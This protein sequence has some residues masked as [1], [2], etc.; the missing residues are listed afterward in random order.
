MDQMPYTKKTVYTSACIALCVVLPMI[1]HAV[2][3]AGNVWLPMHFP[4]LLC[5][6]ICG[7]KLGLFCGLAGPFISSI[8][9]Q[10]PAAAYLPS[11]MLELAAYGAVS[12]IAI[13]IIRTGKYTMDIIIS[14]V[15]SIIIGR[16]VYGIANALIFQ[17][18]N[19]SM[20]AWITASFVTALPG[21]ILE[22]ILIPLVMT[23]LQ[24]ASLIP[25][26]Y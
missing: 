6:L 7:W 8:L 25:E 15:I 24:N 11:M 12:G 10:M 13:R 17:S 19:Y 23:A 21:I 14:L 16:V 5:G 18:G 1:F 9:T 20:N 26:R 4:V 2:P 3:N 22:L